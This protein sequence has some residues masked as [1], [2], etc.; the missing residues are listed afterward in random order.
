MF[1]G[2]GYPI[3]SIGNVVDKNIQ[4]V[5]KMFN[6][7]DRIKYLDI[8]S[9]D[10]ISKTV[11]G[12]TKYLLKD[13][14]SRAQYVLQQGDILYSTVRPNLQ[15]IAI[16]P[17]SDANVVGSTGFCILRCQ[18]VTNA[19][20]WGVITSDLFT[21]KMVSL[22]SGANYPAVTDK[23][24]Y[25]YEFPLPPKED[26]MQFASFV[27]QLDKS[28]FVLQICLYFIE[29]IISHIKNSLFRRVSYV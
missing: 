2:Q 4:R 25:A 11:T 8:S 17:Y 26:Q 12:T 29:M 16:N 22:S 6:K 23:T 3:E 28:K 18:K 20:M 15:N 7:S 21:D 10:N 1:Y 24:V 9:I 27:Q 5:A 13:A 19:Y 14:P